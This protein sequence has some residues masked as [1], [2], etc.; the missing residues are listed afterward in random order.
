M[1]WKNGLWQELDL[2]CHMPHPRCLSM[3]EYR[4]NF[5][6]KRI[7]ASFSSPSSFLFLLSLSLPLISC[8]FHFIL[9]TVSCCVTQADS[10]CPSSSH[11]LPCTSVQEHSTTAVKGSVS[12]TPP[13]IL[14]FLKQRSSFLIDRFIKPV[15]KLLLWVGEFLWELLISFE[16]ARGG[17]WEHSVRRAQR[18]EH[19]SSLSDSTD[20]SYRCDLGFRCGCC[21]EQWRARIEIENEWLR[22][23][24]PPNDS[25]GQAIAVLTQFSLYWHRWGRLILDTRRPKG[26]M[27]RTFYCSFLMIASSETLSVLWHLEMPQWIRRMIF[28][29]NRNPPRGFLSLFPLNRENIIG[30]RSNIRNQCLR[31]VSGLGGGSMMTPGKQFWSLPSM[32][33]L[34]G[35]PGAWDSDMPPEGNRSHCTEMDL[36]ATVRLKIGWLGRPMSLISLISVIWDN[37]SLK[38]SLEWGDI[39]K[40]CDYTQHWMS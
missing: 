4:Q 17:G 12:P 30:P 25:E 28:Q 31:S 21:G 32:A 40:V 3:K 24:Y 33:L 35:H 22:L 7:P 37:I 36:P 23:V 9:E 19:H 6:S 38:P 2:C 27:L 10:R 1:P 15:A 11:S 29:V 13:Q 14:Q 20:H 39:Q 18:H 5:D 26:V 34:W 8:P 16:R